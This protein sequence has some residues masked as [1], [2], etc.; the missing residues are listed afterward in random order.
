MVKTFPR[1]V[2]VCLLAVL[3]SARATFA[4]S[5]DVLPLEPPAFDGQASFL[6]AFC[7]TFT[8]TTFQGDRIARNP[9]V[10]ADGRY[11]AFESDA[12]NLVN[13]SSVG[14]AD[15]N[16]ATDIF[17]YD[18]QTCT[19][20]RVS[21]NS[22]EQ[23]TRNDTVETNPGP[24]VPCEVNNCSQAW[25]RRPSISA[26][27]RY[28]AFVSNAT[29][30]IPNDVN[31]WRDV[32]VRD[33]VAGTTERINNVAPAFAGLAFPNNQILAPTD[34]PSI[35]GNGR[36]VAFYSGS[37]RVVSGDNNSRWDIF[38]TDRDTDTTVRVST[39]SSG[40]QSNDHSGVYNVTTSLSSLPN[41]DHIGISND[42]RYIAFVS[43]ASNLV[44]NDT[45]NVCNND[46][47]SVADDNCSDIFVKDTVTGAITRASVSNTG[48]QANSASTYPDISDNGQIISFQS[49]ASNL[50]QGDTNNF[51]TNPGTPNNSNCADIFVRDLSAGTT[52]R[53]SVSTTGTQGGLAS[54]QP[55]ISANGNYVAFVSDSTLLFASDNNQLQDI[56]VR[57][58]ARGITKLV[59]SSFNGIQSNGGS[60]V[61]EIS[62]N[63]QFIAFESDARNIANGDLNNG[64][65]DVFNTNWPFISA[66]ADFNIALNGNFNQP[67]GSPTANWTAYGTPTL[68]A[69]QWRVSQDAATP[70]N[71]FLEFYRATNTLT[72][73]V[74]Q[75]TTQYLWQNS[76]IEVTFRAGNSN[77][78]LR[79]RITILVH[80]ADFTDLQVCTFWIPPNTP[81]QT[82]P[83]RIRTRNSRSWLNASISIYASNADGQ[84]WLQLDDVTMRYAPS[85]SVTEHQCEDPTAPGPGTG[86]DSANLINNGDFS[87]PL[88]GANG[89]TLFGTPD[90]AT[91][92]VARNNSG[93]LEF[94]RNTGTSSAVVFQNT[95]ITTLPANAWLD[96]SF[97][98]GNTSAFR[99]RITVLLHTTDFTDLNVCT[100]WINGLTP[101][102]TYTMRVYTT[103]AWDSGASISFYAS[104][105]DSQGWYRVDNVNVRYRPTLSQDATTCSLAGSGASAEAVSEE[106]RP[107]LEPTAT[108]EGGELP[109]IAT[110]APTDAVM[111]EGELGEETPPVE[112]TLSVPTATIAPTLEATATAE[113]TVEPPTA[114]LEVTTAVPTQE[115]TATVPAL[116]PTV[117]PTAAPEVTPETP[118]T[119][120]PLEPTIEP[121][122]PA[123]DGG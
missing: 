101:L 91:A 34:G 66:E 105:A 10:S 2:V 21:L 45:N 56:F 30:L 46:G 99:K 75:N 84:G 117:E 80:E 103:K 107:T 59:S 85:L 37:G 26:D 114:T 96:A 22:D 4:Q 53:V 60:F 50:V 43:W 44:P 1:L 95:G 51:C 61:P 122:T 70:P 17:V 49:I 79:K 47:G 94:L 3:V 71:N 31:T 86:A 39:D 119:D 111:P 14:G 106:F 73:L 63:G 18:R 23:Q 123:P 24:D 82:T 97:Q 42:G 113:A 36:F 87:S 92:I 69:I 12:T 88:G 9:V 110:A 13:A 77:P 67:L 115:P 5:P 15:T 11:M 32:F 68:A 112:P 54:Y 81:L 58:R 29:N 90:T 41:P 121:P 109:V 72:A 76:P 52:T 62:D 8:V 33:R 16:G 100:F 104:T 74:Y 55:T 78:T 89:W 7:F 83:Y 57:D 98:L 20:E 102:Q 19:I 120:I 48:E 27:G 28:V 93:I 64:V 25:S 118:P 108:P 35:S 38:V 116:A 40:G 65:R 6:N